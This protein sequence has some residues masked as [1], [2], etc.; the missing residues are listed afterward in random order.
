MQ[1]IAG[2]NWDHDNFALRARPA[3]RSE[4][5]PE[6]LLTE[7]TEP[8]GDDLLAEEFAALAMHSDVIEAGV[9]VS[10]AEAAVLAAEDAGAVDQVAMRR[11]DRARAEERAVLVRLQRE[12]T[13][14]HTVSSDQNRV[15]RGRAS[16]SGE[17]AA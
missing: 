10:E 14:A 13:V 9:A 17:V 4:L 16:T 1:A 8:A 7:V 2:E 6:A 3:T 5:H 12:R 15:D 11:L